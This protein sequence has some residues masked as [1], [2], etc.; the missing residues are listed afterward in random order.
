MDEKT[1]ISVVNRLNAICR[2][3]EEAT[4]SGNLMLRQKK[5]GE[6]QGFAEA[7]CFLGITPILHEGTH[8]LDGEENV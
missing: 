8:I 3:L 4:S 5:I 6:Y 7:L 2:E 1:K